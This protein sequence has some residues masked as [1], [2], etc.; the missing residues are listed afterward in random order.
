MQVYAEKSAL[1]IE[2]DLFLNFVCITVSKQAA[3][4][5]YPFRLG[6]ALHVPKYLSL[7]CRS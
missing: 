5:I 4:G 2:A 7:S 6:I 1:D 3:I